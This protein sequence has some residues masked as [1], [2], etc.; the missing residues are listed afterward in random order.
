MSSTPITCTLAR[1][2]LAIGGLLTSLSYWLLPTLHKLLDT[3]SDGTNRGKRV[4]TSSGQKRGD[5]E[6][7]RLNIAETADL[8]IDVAVV[9]DFHGSHGRG[10]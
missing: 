4:P 8:V 3:A 10:S 1:Y 6:I 5:L 9:H 2:T 7:K